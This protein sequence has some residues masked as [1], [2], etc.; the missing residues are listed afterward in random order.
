MINSNFFYFIGQGIK[1]FWSNKFVSLAAVGVLA[2]CLFIMG[3]FWLIYQNVEL[4]I[5]K[6]E[7]ENETVLF[8][9]DEMEGAVDS[10]KAAL[11]IIANIDTITFKSK[12]EAFIEYKE[13]YSDEQDLL[14]ELEANNINPLPNS[15]TVSMKNIELYDETL[16]QLEQIEGVSSIRARSDTVEGIMS[17]ANTVYFISYWIMGLL[18]FA[19][20]FII[21]NTIKIARFVNRKTINIMKLVGATDWSVR[22]PFIYEG[23][24]IGLLAA[25]ISFGFEWYAY[26]YV[27]ENFIETINI[28]NIL[29]FADVAST[30]FITFM[31]AGLSIGVIGSA[32]SIRKYLD[33]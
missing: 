20:M 18:F 1:Y 21:M 33:I 19:S 12:E 5:D 17:V 16:Y 25:V 8:V 7:N 28:V 23:A 4:N 22:W 29:P 27:T 11:E 6:M 24:I 14:S 31:G 10:V 13:S 32:L 26:D 3:N 9:D 15:Y 30:L 2:A